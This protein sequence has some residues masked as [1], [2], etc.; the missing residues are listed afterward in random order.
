MAIQP[1]HQGPGF[2]VRH[3]QPLLGIPLQEEGQE[4]V[5][6]FAEEGQADATLPQS[7][8][9]EALCLA[10]AWHDLDWDTM[11]QALHRIR[12]ESPPSPPLAL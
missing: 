9:Q 2:V 6:Y 5:C 12:H 4:V 8:T 11:E 7:A 10:G 3:D 1:L